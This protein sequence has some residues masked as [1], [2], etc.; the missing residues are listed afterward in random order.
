MDDL[1]QNNDLI[2][3]EKDLDILVRELQ[4]NEMIVSSFDNNSVKTEEIEI[5]KPYFKALRSISVG[6]FY[7]LFDEINIL[8][9]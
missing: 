7:H 8:F 4:P 9:Y 3:K 5:E 2:N 6:M 1:L